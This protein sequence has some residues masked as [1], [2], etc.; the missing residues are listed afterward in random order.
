MGREELSIP[1]FVHEGD[2][3]RI[4][5]IIKRLV[6]ALIAAV[7]LIFASNA[8][9]LIAWTQ[10]DYSGSDSTT[11]TQTRMIDVDAEDGT[12]NY[13]GNDGSITNGADTSNDSHS[14]KKDEAQNQ[15]E[16]KRQQ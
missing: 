7:A 10:Y 3:A 8:A 14:N 9:W 15:K 4:E 13:I 1:Y 11:T 16:E 6:V 2:M 5:R 12:A